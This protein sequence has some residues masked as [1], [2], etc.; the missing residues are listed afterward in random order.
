M[1]KPTA[2][3]PED[4]RESVDENIRCGLIEILIL[5]MLSNRDM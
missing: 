2:G 5:S 3:M 1:K 4:W